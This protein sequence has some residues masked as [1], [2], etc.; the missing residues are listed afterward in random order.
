MWSIRIYAFV[1]GLF[2]SFLTHAQYSSQN[3]SLISHWFNPGQAGEP[4][5]GVKYNSVWGWVDTAHNTEYAI[6]GSGSGTHFIDLSNI[7]TPVQRDFVP[8]K[9]NLCIWREYKTY[10]NYLYT[11]SDDASPNSFQI[12]DMSYLP[13]SV[14]VVYD[15][16]II[17]ERAHT[18]YIDGDKLYCASVTK[19]STAEYHSMA[20]YSLANPELPVLLRGLEED[21]P[22]ISFAHDMFV[23]N[24][25]VYASCGTQG[26]FIYKYNSDTTFSLINS[27]TAYPDQGYNHSSSLTPDGK[28]LIFCDES[29]K[30]KSVKIIDVSD[31]Q[32]ISIISTFKST[33]GATA[34]NPYIYGT[35]HVVIAYYQDGLQ[36]FDISD[37]TTPVRTGFFDTDTL[38]GT[39]DNF[40]S[41]PYHG[42]WGAYLDLPS[43]VILASDMQNGL[44][45]L[46]ASDA[47]SIKEKVNYTNSITVFPNPASSSIS[48]A[49]NL[50]NTDVISTEI[51]DMS[52]RKIISRKETMPAGSST[53]TIPTEQLAA[54]IYILKTSGKE[55]IYSQK[56]IKE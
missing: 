55:I 39:N 24:D 3:M 5:H 45:I 53:Y 12:I 20:V 49:I 52:G 7:S 21:Y 48:I 1:T 46:N 26:L 11:I 36:I 38:K 40:I 15:G 32:N 54:G 31:L 4:N 56:I 23:R 13:D 10:K 33:E 50:K 37:P 43:K 18:L 51:I 2:I 22:N 27:L 41:D 34:H 16:T 9:R 8:G 35:R 17:F 6:L 29:P 19:P 28:T 44:Y 42:C 25:T 47:L 30:N 14:H